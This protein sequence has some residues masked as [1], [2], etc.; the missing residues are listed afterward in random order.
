[1][2]L[3]EFFGIRR[4]EVKKSDQELV[5]E[6][7]EESAVAMNKARMEHRQYV[8]AISNFTK[9]GSIQITAAPKYYY[10]G[11]SGCNFNTIS[12]MSCIPYTSISKM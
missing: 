5:N 9:V 12:F 1:M 10:T 2:S 7:L 8:R 6:I 4:K 3:L 11:S